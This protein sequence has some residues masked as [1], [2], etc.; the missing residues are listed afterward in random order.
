MANKKKHITKEQLSTIIDM[1]LSGLTYKN[2][3]SIIDISDSAISNLL[4]RIEFNE[5]YNEIKKY[6]SYEK[7]FFATGLK[8]GVK[9]GTSKQML[10]TLPVHSNKTKQKSE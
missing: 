7:A 5:F 6:D 8:N 2:I 3:A 9:Y 4:K 10:F 1:R